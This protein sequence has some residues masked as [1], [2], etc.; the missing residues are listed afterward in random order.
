MLGKNH[1][2][3]L[4]V[5]VKATLQGG[6]RYTPYDREKTLMH[7]NYDMKYKSD[8]AYSLQHSP[9]LFIHYTLSYKMNRHGLTHEFSIKHVNCTG[10]NNYFGYEYCYRTDEFKESSFNFSLPNISYKIEF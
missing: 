9:M 10:T 5:N 6:D 8:E 4:S 2:N 1:N 3:M 7:P